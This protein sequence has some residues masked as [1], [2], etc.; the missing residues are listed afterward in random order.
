MPNPITP[1]TAAQEQATEAQV[2]KEGYPKRVLIALDQFGAALAGD[3]NDETISSWSA[4]ES[5]K[6]NP[7]GKAI[8]AVLNVFQ[9]DHGA[10]AMAGDVERAKEVT[11]LEHT[12]GVLPE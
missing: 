10:K 8:S 1:L 3:D 11:V 6:G 9:K 12:D 4:R 2:V 7:L 5:V